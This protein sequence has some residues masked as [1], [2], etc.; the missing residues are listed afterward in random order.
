MNRKVRPTGNK[1]VLLPL[2]RERLNANGLVA[3]PDKYQPENRQWMVLEIGPKVTD[4]Q[5]GDCVLTPGVFESYHTWTD[6]VVICE[7]DRLL[8]VWRP[9]AC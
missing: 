9:N 8:A 4:L 6:G 3:I 7:S 5:R 1:V 2:R